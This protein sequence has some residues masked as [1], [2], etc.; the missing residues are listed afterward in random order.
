MKI[1]ELKHKQKKTLFVIQLLENSA[2][3]T[4]IAMLSDQSSGINKDVLKPI[5]EEIVARIDSIVSSMSSEQQALLVVQ[6]L[7]EAS[8][9][10][11]EK[12]PDNFLVNKTQNP[13]Y[14]Y[15]EGYYN[16]LIGRKETIQSDLKNKQIQVPE[17]QMEGFCQIISAIAQDAG[18][19][20]MEA[21]QEKHLRRSPRKKMETKKR[22]ERDSSGS[23]DSDYPS[24]KVQF[25]DAER[26]NSEHEQQNRLT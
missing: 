13:L 12:L 18:Q 17:E 9:S 8:R 19:K 23:N 25:A 22:G 5:V 15:C 2:D 10:G 16:Y 24:K 1:S 21:S 26:V 7:V 20:I 11:E 4:T 6:N 3:L 14:R